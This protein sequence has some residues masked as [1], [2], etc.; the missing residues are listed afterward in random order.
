MAATVEAASSSASLGISALSAAALVVA[1]LGGSGISGI[2]SGSAFLGISGSSAGQ[3]M[4][5]LGHTLLTKLICGTSIA[6]LC[7]R[8]DLNGDI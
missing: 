3:T 7:F 8:F 6:L 4:G 5:D 2:G 1:S